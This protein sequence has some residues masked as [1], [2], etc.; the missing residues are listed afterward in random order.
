MGC[1]QDFHARYLKAPWLCKMSNERCCL[2]SARND[3][4]KERRREIWEGRPLQESSIET[5]EVVDCVGTTFHAVEV[6][7]EQKRRLQKCLKN[8]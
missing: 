3:R 7:Q 6:F 5:E 8:K 4:L 1:L 2:K